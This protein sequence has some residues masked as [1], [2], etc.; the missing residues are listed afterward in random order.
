MDQLRSIFGEGS[1]L[2]ISQ[3]ALRGVVVLVLTL[4]MIRIAGRR[5]FGQHSPFDACL[6]VLLG[7]ILARCVVGAS[8]FWPTIGTG[9][10]LALSHRVMAMLTIRSLVLDRWINGQPRTLA[11][12]GT[13]SRG[14][15]ARALVTEADLRQAVR[16][17][18]LADDLAAVH[19]VILERNGSLS[20]VQQAP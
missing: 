6:T 14:E 18:A 8:P 11:R 15:M 13:L 19:A 4:V 7:S 10:A 12:D 20:V 9:V 5:S 3:M 16:E 2:S 17:N 1:D